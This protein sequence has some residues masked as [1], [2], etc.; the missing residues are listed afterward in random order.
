MTNY[1]PDID[2]LRAIAVLAVIF[3]H[4]FEDYL[5]GGFLG[6]DVFF[7]I[8]GFVISM[9]LFGRED[10]GF[11]RHMAGF[12]LRRL[13]RLMP[14]LLVCVLI[15]CIVLIFID[16]SPDTSLITGGWAIFGLSNFYLYD[17][18]LDYFSTSVAYNAF[19]HTWSL[20]VEEQFYLFFPVLFWLI[21]KGARDR[22]L[23]TLGIVIGG[24]SVL[25]FIAFLVLQA[26]ATTFVYY[27][28]PT[29]FWQIGTGVA[30]ACLVSGGRRL[31]PVL[32]G[33]VLQTGYIILLGVIFA[34]PAEKAA[35]GHV[36]AVL[37]AA[38]LLWSGASAEPA[39]RV[40]MNPVSV[41]F[42]RISYSLYLWHWPFLVFGLLAQDSWVSQP[43]V[44]L[45]MACVVA[46]LSY[47][48]V[49]QP[50]R[51]VLTPVPKVRHFA[52][53]SAAMLGVI[54]TVAL[55]NEY[56]KS[57]PPDH[58]DSSLRPSYA[59]L[60]DSDLTFNPHCVVALHEPHLQLKPD[61]Y[62]KCTYPPLPQGNGRM[63]W[64]LG[65]SHAGH[66]Q[67][68][69]V[70]LR[71][72]E[73]FG[74]HLVETPGNAF[75]SP[76]PEGFAERDTLMEAVR[77]DWKPGDAVV[78]GRLFL[79]RTENTR[80]FDDLDIWYQKADTFAGTLAG[81][82]IQLILPGPPPMFQFEDLR[83][84]NPRDVL[85]C[86]IDRD[87]QVEAVEDVHDN[88]KA[89]A[90]RYPHVTFL[91]VFEVFCP[92]TAPVCSPVRDGVFMMRDRD[93]FNVFGAE[94]LMPHL[95]DKMTQN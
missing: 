16:S 90:G 46:G 8:S 62:D 18:E 31:P 4:A 61:T 83:A 58:F 1:R 75:P 86:A 92:A 7:V 94:I 21:L 79:N 71:Q 11:A 76:N 14:A 60:P 19:T 26:E 33:P 77:R 82:G 22:F 53:A 43:L 10:T 95:S 32:S 87:R 41:Y 24:L 85:S 51:T 64:V 3:G 49:E 54:L 2:G 30:L 45:L 12:L 70:K 29:R 91:N 36:A 52:V 67:G 81:Q 63:I 44:A 28:M 84:C 59:N 80:P 72:D 39:H 88:L 20:G 66:L 69:L 37:A 48:F 73:G 25:S 6:V 5:P 68:G 56:R 47:R 34:F 27:M 42:G 17:Q 23:A 15:T 55:G 40:L 93:H 13:K 89:I 74:F 35:T 38:L 65:D 78:L 9:S 57:L 50:V